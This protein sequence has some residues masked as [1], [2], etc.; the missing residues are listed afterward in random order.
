MRLYAPPC[1]ANVDPFHTCAAPALSSPHVAPSLPTAICASCVPV[2]GT[3]VE[4]SSLCTVPAASIPHTAPS[5]PAATVSSTHGKGPSTCPGVYRRS[6]TIFPVSYT[7][8]RAHE[9]P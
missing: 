1:G 6:S 2:T 5:P 7:H 8:L 9:T 4:P 3:N